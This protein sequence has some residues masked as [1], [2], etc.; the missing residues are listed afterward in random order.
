MVRAA[1]SDL[2]DVRE[3]ATVMR[4]ALVRADADGARRAMARYQEAAASAHDHTSGPTW[5]VFEAVPFLGDDAEGIAT[6]ADV[7]DEIGRDGLPPI[8]DAAEPGHRRHLPAGGRA[9]PCGPHRGDG[10]ARRA[11]RA[12]LRRRRQE[13]RRRRHRQTS[14]ARSGS[15]SARLDESGHRRARD[16]RLDV[17]G[18]ADDPADD[19]HRPA[20]LLPDGHA[21]QRG[22]CAAAAGCRVPC[23]WCGCRTARSTSSSRRT[24]PSLGRDTRPVVTLT[25]EENRIFGRI[26]GLAA[27][28][29]TLTPD[30][31]RSADIIRA[32]WEREMGGRLD[33]MFFV[34]PVAVSYLLRGTGTVAVPGYVPVDA[35]NV[36]QAVENEIYRL[37][38]DRSIQSDYQQA[39]AKAVFD[40]F[41]AGRG[42]T[43]ESI[44]GLVTAV[45]EGRI[46]M[47]ELRAGEPGRDRRH[48]DRRG[49]LR[50][51]EQRPRRRD[52]PQRRW[53]DEDAVL[54][55]VRR[56]RDPA[57]LR[58]RPPGAG[59]LDR[60]PERHPAR[61][62]RP[63]ALDHRRR[64]PRPAGVA[65]GPNCSWST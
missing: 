30:F 31:Q 18:G 60:L 43:A 58:R 29:A 54:P 46:R 33:G 13:A 19:G 26:L 56:H 59:R 44:R 36:V 64:V 22:A 42:N 23:R 3:S 1:S 32:R 6:A 48:G 2:A 63:A 11:E 41:A 47:H 62:P 17:P 40:A 20:P 50:P 27:V 52:L 15:S 65:G 28:D 16:A 4:A 25:P 39:V 37:T 53:P 24:C 21:E 5:K 51:G 8:A 9:L 14:S 10:A 61:R 12:R 34:D 38:N 55:Q 35:A 45:Q 7:L 57:L 49:V